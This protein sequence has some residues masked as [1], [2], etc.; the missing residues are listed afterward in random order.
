MEYEILKNILPSCAR[1]E[2][3]RNQIKF[4]FTTM[5]FVIIFILYATM[6]WKKKQFL[7]RVKK[8]QNNLLTLNQTVALSVWLTLDYIL[9][10]CCV[11]IIPQEKILLFEMLKLI[12]ID[13]ICYRFLVPLVLLFNSKKIFPELWSRTL[14][15]KSSFYMTEREKIP[16]RPNTFI[17]TETIENEL[18]RK[19][20]TFIYVKSAV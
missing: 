18:N 6:M 3:G 12:I 19:K 1:P 8:R 16:R 5:S 4:A 15:G 20:G 10:E 7:N 13:N 14:E 17:E 11:W 2:E 9:V